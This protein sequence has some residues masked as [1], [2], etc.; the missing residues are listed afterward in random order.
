VLFC[1]V[2]PGGTKPKVSANTFLAAGACSIVAE[3]LSIVF[4][5]G[6][7]KIVLFKQELNPSQLLT[8]FLIG[9]GSGLLIVWRSD[10]IRNWFGR[11]LG[12]VDKANG[13]SPKPKEPPKAKTRV[14]PGN[15]QVDK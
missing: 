7:T 5:A 8:V 6:G 12:E 2:L 9:F 11:V 1:L 4:V 14:P 3:A 10:E 15:A 13:R